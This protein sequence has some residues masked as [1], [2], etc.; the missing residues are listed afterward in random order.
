MV[1]TPDTISGSDLR[2]AEWSIVLPDSVS[3]SPVT[4]RAAVTHFIRKTGL[5][6][7]ASR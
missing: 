1:V 4:Y 7:R 3:P 2:L 5:A 6:N